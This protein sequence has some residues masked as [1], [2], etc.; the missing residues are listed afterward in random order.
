MPEQHRGPERQ[1]ADASP[2]RQ[3]GEGS[4]V[5]W[6]LG[7][8]A[9]V[10]LDQLSKYAITSHFSY[11]EA[12]PLT[13][14]FDL[15]LAHNQGA[16]FGMLND[17]GGWQ[18]W[19]FTAIA[20]GASAWVLLLLRKHRQQKLFCLALA[21]VLGGA[22]GNL[23]D[24]IAYGYVVDFLDFHWNLNH[25]PAFNLADSAITCGAALLLLDGFLKTRRERAA[26]TALPG[27]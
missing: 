21:L 14:F 27:E 10:I 25:F 5:H 23:V 4:Y 15:V 7:A 3:R 17:A 2:A 12:Y 9:V 18:R 13:P 6:L 16:A 11:G 19:L 22:L 20:L 8:V 24:R 1:P 26:R